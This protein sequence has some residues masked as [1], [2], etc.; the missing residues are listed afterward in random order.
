VDFL[1]DYETMQL[2]TRVT[3]GY[4]AAFL[5]LQHS[6]RVYFSN[7]C[8]S[9]R[10]E[11]DDILFDRR[12]TIGSDYGEGFSTFGSGEFCEYD[13][14]KMNSN[15]K[16]T[17]AERMRHAM[18]PDQ[19]F[20]LIYDLEVLVDV[21]DMVQE[22]WDAVAC[23]HGF[24]KYDFSVRPASHIRDMLAEKILMYVFKWTDDIKM[25]RALAFEFHETLLHL[26]ANKSALRDPNTMKWLDAVSKLHIPC[27]IVSTFD[28]QTVHRVLQQLRLDPTKYVIISAEDELESR[29]ERFLK[30]SLELRRAPEQCIVFCTCVESIIAAHNTT[31][32]AVAL[33]G[34]TPAPQLA[35][36]DLL[37]FQ[38]FGEL[39]IF[40]LRRLFANKGHD[41]MDLN[42]L[43]ST[44]EER[45][46]KPIQQATIDPMEP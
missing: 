25:A 10:R 11:G 43:N 18:H 17:G 7:T 20:G 16:A 45:D 14:E 35:A 6:R 44:D 32:R 21:D 13:V 3:G 33:P 28:R 22:A 38:G 15:L 36:A 4:P 37:L 23:R 2:T 12:K 46:S 1:R 8:A 5:R 29:S 24:R 31:M 27:A 9:H 42:K 30:A 40:N 39:T 26:L 41:F 34:D 19:A